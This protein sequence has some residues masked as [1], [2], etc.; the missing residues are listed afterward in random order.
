MV[1]GSLRRRRN[2]MGEIHPFRDDT[3]K[4]KCLQKSSAEVAFPAIPL[5][6]R[7]WIDGR[8]Q[9][10]GPKYHCHHFSIPGSHMKK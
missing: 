3:R 1:L 9:L 5:A 8:G 10:A 6:A 4:S 7:P 2:R